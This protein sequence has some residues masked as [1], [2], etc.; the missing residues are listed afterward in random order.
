MWIDSNHDLRRESSIIGE[1]LPFGENRILIESCENAH[2][3]TI[4]SKSF[5]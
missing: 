2:I 4:E 3:K 1:V 5:E